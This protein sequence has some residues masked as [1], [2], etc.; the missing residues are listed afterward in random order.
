MKDPTVERGKRRGGG[1]KLTRS[2]T[3]TV[4]FDPKL[5]YLTELAARKHRRTLSSFIEWAIEDSLTRVVLYRGSGYQGD[6]DRTVADE[7]AKLWDV[8]EAERF[9]RLAIHYPELL[10]HQEQE[11]WKLLL[12]S[13][14][15]GPAHTRDSS[16]E[17]YWNWAML[18][19]MVFPTIRRFWSDLVMAHTEGPAAARQWVER[20]VGNIAAGNVYPAQSAKGDFDDDIPF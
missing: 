10:T 11:R 15:L 18:E 3:V 14:L 4:R 19:D 1:S 6:V 13:G 17:R 5:R 2:E 9:V 12:D 8:D 16:G 20:T 7:T